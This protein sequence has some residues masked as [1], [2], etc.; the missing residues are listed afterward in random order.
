MTNHYPLT[1][2]QII[3]GNALEVLRSWPDNC[4]DHCIA[5]PPFN[6]SKTKGLEWAF[7]SHVTM[8][9]QWDRFTEDDFFL[10]N[11]DW[12]RE[13][14]RVVK[15]NGNIIVFGTYH[16]IYQIG[17]ILKNKLN[18]RLL[19]SITWY[20][21]NAQ[22]NITARMLT[23]STEQIIWAVNGTPEGKNKAR[24]WTFNYWD[25]KKLNGGKQ[26]RN[27]WEIPVTSKSERG[28]GKHPSQKPLVLMERLVLLGTQEGN[29]ILDPFGGA[30]TLA[31]AAEKHHRNWILI[32]TVESYIE[33]A[34]ARIAEQRMSSLKD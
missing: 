23:E 27:L 7:S 25:A 14:V 20:K 1:L 4:I 29:L 31:I 3:T 10:F 22:P 18:R 24:K 28:K 9:E 6:I 13:V 30:G 33:I 32:E 34:K 8:Q 12:L 26:M 19:N 16:N 17:Y 21:P 15:P 11:N 5:D 2:N